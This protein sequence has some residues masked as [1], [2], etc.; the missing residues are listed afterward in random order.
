MSTA[1]YPA[2]IFG[3]A[4][5]SPC[6]NYRYELS[7]SWDSM[8]PTIAFVMLNPSTADAAE[9]DPTIRRC[10]GFA[11]AWGYG[12]LKVYNLFVLRTPDPADL[13]GH[14]YPEPVTTTADLYI[15]KATECA[16]ILCAWG[17]FLFQARPAETIGRIGVVFDILSGLELLALATNRDGSPR[18]PLYVK[19]DTKP[20]V[21]RAGRKPGVPA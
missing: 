13:A 15:R 9:D 3:S 18:H 14:E 2:R 4:D 8:L 12:E 6:G 16:A 10:I 11:N 5:I 19:G 7:R 20:I 1:P 21:W 17:A